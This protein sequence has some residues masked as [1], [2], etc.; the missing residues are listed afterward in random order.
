MLTTLKRLQQS[1]DTIKAGLISLDGSDRK[2][3]PEPVKPVVNSTKSTMGAATNLDLRPKEIV[4]KNCANAEELQE[5]FSK[6]GVCTVIPSG[7]GI[8][9]GFA[10]RRDAEMAYVK[11]RMVDN[12]EL[13]IEWNK[14][15]S[16][17]P[18]QVAVEPIR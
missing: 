6:F 18:S 13:D 7:V 12:Q 15:D 17:Q 11:G 3:K 9:I 4:V 14:T 1:H 2:R 16:V 8:I 5:H 10:T